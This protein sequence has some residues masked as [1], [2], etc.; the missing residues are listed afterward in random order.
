MCCFSF[1]RDFGIRCFFAGMIGPSGYTDS[2]VSALLRHVSA[3]AHSPLKGLSRVGLDRGCGCVIRRVRA[4]RLQGFRSNPSIF[5]S[6]PVGPEPE[7][8]LSMAMNIGIMAHSHR[9]S[10]KSGGI[11]LN[12][13]WRPPTQDNLYPQSLLYRIL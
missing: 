13:I 3:R 8:K 10:N 4:R 7:P 2:Q 1:S 12:A 9:N 11:N 5:G 6:D